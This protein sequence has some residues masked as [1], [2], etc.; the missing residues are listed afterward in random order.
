MW[1]ARHLALSRGEK[2]AEMRRRVEF[3]PPRHTSGFGGEKSEPNE[4]V[5]GVHAASSW[6]SIEGEGK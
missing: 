5:S 6:I 1:D 4:A 3:T 2:K